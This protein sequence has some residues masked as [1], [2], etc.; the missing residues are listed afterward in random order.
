VEPALELLDQVLKR[1]VERYGEV[2]SL[3]GTAQ[4]NK[5]LAYMYAEDYPKALPCFQK[6]L[7]IRRASLGVD[8]FDVSVC[9][10]K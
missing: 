10:F 9:V 4:H 2:H 1:H 8:H 3:V 6:A 5:G 7:D